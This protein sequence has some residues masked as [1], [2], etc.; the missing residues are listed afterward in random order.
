MGESDAS[1]EKSTDD[2]RVINVI[3]YGAGSIGRNVADD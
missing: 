2:I 3:I 1:L